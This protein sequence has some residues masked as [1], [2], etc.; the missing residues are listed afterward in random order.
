MAIAKIK[1]IAI[2]Y[3]AFLAG[4]SWCSIIAAQTCLLKVDK[5]SPPEAVPGE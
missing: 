5:L 4:I 2:Y 1:I 3:S